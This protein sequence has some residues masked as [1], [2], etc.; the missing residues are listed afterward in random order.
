MA[1]DRRRLSKK[2]L[3]VLTGIALLFIVYI[4]AQAQDDDKKVPPETGE[5]T[6]RVVNEN[7]QPIPHATIYVT[8]PM[9]TIQSRNSSS[10]DAGNFRVSGL[11][12][13][14]YTVNA[15]VPA[16][17]TPPR[18]RDSLPTYY[19]LG[20]SLTI[21]LIKGGIITG[22]VTSS[23]G[24]PLV[25]IAVR[26]TL[27]RDVNGK[28]PNP[29]R[30]GVDKATDDRGVYRFYGLVPG[31]YVVSAGGR[32]T[33]WYAPNPYDTDAPTYAPSSTRDAAAEITVKAGE[34]VSG[35][36]IR[37][38]GEPGH[39]VSGF[40]SGLSAP[41]FSAPT[42]ITLA[43]IVNGV[44]QASA[45]SFQAPGSKSF[46][47]YGIADGD[48]DLIA[49]ST[50]P[51]GEV[52]ASEA[53]HI[54]VK[55]AD[56]TGVELVVKTL[57]AISGH[58]ALEPSTANECKNKRR[59]SLSEILLLARRSE[60]NISADQLAFPV[61]LVQAAPSKDGDF[62]MRNLTPGQFN[63]SARFFAKYWYLRSIG[64]EASGVKP[65]AAK[66]GPTSQAARQNDAAKNGVKLKFG[67][68]ISGLT[69]TLAEGAAS[70][71]GSIK[72]AAGGIIPP[73]LKVY[74]VPAE[75][76]GAEDVLRFFATPVNADGTFALNN[77][78]PGRYWALARFAVDDEPQSDSK[79]RAPE[80]ADARV[81]VRRAAETA[82]QA[83]EVKPC[84]NVIDYQLPFK[85]SAPKN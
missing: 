56:V 16:Y 60:K 59:P 43:Q 67:E 58:V 69:V 79:L 61:F 13:L 40:A 26:A 27:V 10:D 17:V 78:P 68:R 84:Q 37:Y 47:F 12:A 35:V 21:N 18:D 14:V 73:K 44:P 53:R 24:E 32:G 42:N 38:R 75:K 6:G 22:A 31:T 8:A 85:I 19:R 46:A 76:E 11:D 74:F 54:K 39:A 25:Q 55:G 1:S 80:E 62:M 52:I 23:T 33:Y 64:R 57:A 63:L 49:Q 65:A 28:P 51:G 81:Q 9:A 82:N 45:F 2:S 72:P 29:G 48:Y 77:L 36:D 20:D 70:L 7:G 41:N 30:F 83:V 3:R 4:A 5:I 15:S 34:E 66:D 71:R 50:L